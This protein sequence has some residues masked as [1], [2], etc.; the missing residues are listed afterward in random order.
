MAAHV[1][2]VLSAREA[3]AASKGP[4]GETR[5]SEPSGRESAGI[6][7]LRDASE[8]E[9]ASCGPGLEALPGSATGGPLGFRGGSEQHGGQQSGL[10]SHRDGGVCWLADGPRLQAAQLAALRGYGPKVYE[11]G[12]TGVPVGH[13]ALGGVYGGGGGPASGM[14]GS[15]ASGKQGLLASSY[16]LQQHQYRHLHHHQQQQQQH[17]PAHPHQQQQLHRFVGHGNSLVPSG[18][19]PT[20]N[21]LLTASSPARNYGYFTTPGHGDYVLGGGG[22]GGGPPGPSASGSKAS[23]ALQFSGQSWPTQQ[24]R[25][26][27]TLSP[28]SS[29]QGLS[30]GQTSAMEL[31]AMKRGQ[32]YSTTGAS[33]LPSGNPYT[34]QPIYSP[35]SAQRFPIAATQG[36]GSVAYPQRKQPLSGYGYPAHPSTQ[37]HTYYN[38]P[39][40]QYRPPHYP[41]SEMASELYSV[42]GSGL[43]P[44]KSLPD[45]PSVLPPGRPSSLPDLSGSIDDLPMGGEGLQSVG[46]TG[47]GV[48]G[49]SGGPGSQGESVNPARSPFSPHASPHM[50]GVGGPSPSPV[51][52]PA[53]TS[54]PRSGPL[55]PSPGYMQRNAQPAAASLSPHSIP[56]SQTHPG[57]G[58]YQQF[59]GHQAT[60]YGLQ[61]DFPRNTYSNSVYGG[62]GATPTNAHNPSSPVYGFTRGAVPGQNPR[63]YH[64][65]NFGAG[66]TTATGG[67]HGSAVGLTGQS[68][69]AMSGIQAPGMNRKAQEAAAAVM[70]AAPNSTQA[71][72]IYNRVQPGYS[73]SGHS[74]R[75]FYPPSQMAYNNAHPPSS[76]LPPQD[77]CSQA[78]C[79]AGGQAGYVISV[80]GYRTGTASGPGNQGNISYPTQAGQ[81]ASGNY[82][83]NST[84]SQHVMSPPGTP[85]LA[86]GPDGLSDNRTP[87][88]MQ[89]ESKGKR[90]GPSTTTGESVTRLYELGGEP[91]R[92]RWL[93]HYLSFME[94]RGSPLLSMPAVGRKP[95]D[96]YRLYVAVREIGG[97]TQVN[98]SKKW[99]E[100]STVL[101]VG[102]SSSAASSLKKQYISSLFA[103]ECK[104]ER[105][106]ELPVEASTVFGDVKKVPRVQPPSPAGSGSF[107]GPQTPQST[108]SSMAESSL[109]MKPPTPA[110]T[111]HNQPASLPISRTINL[112]DPFSENGD[113]AFQRCSTSTPNA[114]FHPSTGTTDVSRTPSDLTSQ[115]SY[116]SGRDPYAAMRKGPISDLYCSSQGSTP[117]LNADHFCRTP[118]GA[119]PCAGTVPVVSMPHRQPLYGQPYERRSDHGMDVSS[120]LVPPPDTD[121][122]LFS[123]PRVSNQ[124]RH[125]GYGQ[126]YHGQNPHQ[127]Q[128]SYMG[129]GQ[130]ALYGQQGYKRSME[131]MYG[132][133]S[134]RHEPDPYSM[135]YGPQPPSADTFGS[136]SSPAGFSDRRP[137]PPPPSASA[138]HF[139]FS[140]IPSERATLGPSPAQLPT[141]LSDA[142]VAQSQGQWGPGGCTE[143][144]YPMYPGRGPGQTSSYVGMGRSQH[145]GHGPL[146]TGDDGLVGDA[147]GRQMDWHYGQRMGH[148]TFGLGV[149]PHQAS[150]A[151][152][153][154]PS[155][156]TPSPANYPP[157]ASSKGS[158]LSSTVR[159]QKFVPQVPTSHLAGTSQPSS[160]LPPRKEAPTFPPGSVE[161]TQPNLKP[162]RKLSAKDVLPPEAWRVMM[163]LR[164]GLL[165]ESSW[166]LDTISVLLHDDGSV[167]SF[168]L[169]QLP[170]FLELLLEHL[171]RCLIDLFGILAETEVGRGCPAAFKSS[172]DPLD[173]ETLAATQPLP[174]E[175]ETASL[176][177]VRLLREDN[178]QEGCGSKDKHGNG[179]ECEDQELDNC[180]SRDLEQ[181]DNEASIVEDK[182]ATET[183]DG[184]DVNDDEVRNS[185]PQS[186]FDQTQTFMITSQRLPQRSRFSQRRIVIVPEDHSTAYVLD[187]S[188][189]F[190]HPQAFTSGHLHWQLGGGDTTEHIQL[191]LDGGEAALAAADKAIHREAI[192][193]QTTKQGKAELCL[194]T[195]DLNGHP[196]DACG[197]NG[198]EKNDH[199]FLGFE[200]QTCE[201]LSITYAEDSGLFEDRAQ[202]LEEEPE[203]YDDRPLALVP[204]WF[205][206]IYGRCLC[207]SNILRSL[208]FVP[209]NDGEMAHHPGLLLLLGRLLLLRH[210]HPVHQW[211]GYPSASPVPQHDGAKPLSLN[212]RSNEET[213]APLTSQM[214]GEEK[215]VKTELVFS[216]VREGLSLLTES[217][218][219]EPGIEEDEDPNCWEAWQFDL[220]EI[221][222]ENAL[223][224]LANIAGRLDLSQHLEI[225]CFPLLDGL[226]HW[227]VCP[228]ACAR[229]PFCSLAAG[230]ATLSPQRLALEALCKLAVKEANVDL[231]LATPPFA[232]VE[233]LLSTLVHFVGERRSPVGREMSIALLA[234]LVAAG[235]GGPARV[236]AMQKGTV[237]SL[238]SFLEDGLMAA[239]HS[240]QQQ[241]QMLEPPSVDMLRRA[242]GVLLAL[243]RLEDSQSYFALHESRLLDIAMSHIL[244]PYIS[245]VVADILFTLGHT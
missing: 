52:S 4:S 156:R 145:Q 139:P 84:H 108:S 13:S 227:T 88:P 160:L 50:S 210:R 72:T 71:R 163:A 150:A 35:P 130:Q 22:A 142:P 222:R 135:P 49:N 111:P 237:A 149:H 185:K 117:R 215:V 19:T 143:L 109:E 221:L 206:A 128:P 199:V 32:V 10:N 92:R 123:S 242:A 44:G 170:G 64:N 55:S 3:D 36:L 179:H 74:P 158:S 17:Q 66:G 172:P 146:P 229:D 204:S 118:P 102:T 236:V 213:K 240:S 244:N 152:G 200:E 214:I 175:E 228:A 95:L 127:V 73:V 201:G 54:Q 230:V 138:S 134:K 31:M 180:N 169:N 14:S 60:S 191:T 42:R 124:T 56:S 100:L 59:Y 190:G 155:Y 203:S 9:R 114:S 28:G 164:S 16:G 15:F 6:R 209:G 106:E 133:T 86:S 104:M 63:P 233:R 137:H 87:P 85:G 121:P 173:P 1:G 165:A 122:V 198:T 174:N 110:S 58:S 234:S 182:M 178:Q 2:P 153:H 76:L 202:R 208:S 239:L 77:A 79:Q 53:S 91:E 132:P 159:L 20:L 18:A 177:N 223:V 105:S 176:T 220:A 187:H 167:S 21:H 217:S 11:A 211:F 12:R 46:D 154:H 5:H 166:A 120:G 83:G 39:A 112:Q 51:G 45:E 194:R 141:S 67:V 29:G 115:D 101:A 94:E 62:V 148:S 197:T 61:G 183:E 37:S 224:T 235:D 99:R 231:V 129:H 225:I 125:D 193:K 186:D 68:P 41:S 245:P 81:N 188:A 181:S 184:K 131:G 126:L 65:N 157:V 219:Q 116:M 26:Q 78:G 34:V 119:L 47:T 98:K 97:L 57:S 40:T 162:R 205:E 93:D 207:V 69:S 8:A 218:I 107:Q 238:I 168:N 147:C 151:T 216:E 113:P 70:Q 23:E 212:P 80:G 7:E 90:T 27:P 25:I 30:R 24:Q 171:R 89:V 75:H 243:A 226:L 195:D 103:Y 192:Q 43:T 196:N 144:T 136:F 82:T 48:G 38:Q 189:H 140:Y 33:Y 241:H 232:R 96:L 161:A